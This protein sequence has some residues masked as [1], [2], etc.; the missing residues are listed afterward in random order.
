MKTLE[1]NSGASGFKFAII[2]SRFNEFI[3]NRLLE[4]ALAC[5]KEHNYTDDSIQ[6]VKVPGAFEIPLVAD[7]LAASKKYDAIIC[8]GAVIKGETAHFEYV[9]ENAAGGIAQVSLKYGLP[10]IFGVLT[11]YTVEQAEERSGTKSGNNGWEAALT[12][13]EMADLVKQLK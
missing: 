1:G 6:I 13:I 9:S 11:T 4:G 10:V 8:L 2:L 5:L 12:A 7:K 3:G